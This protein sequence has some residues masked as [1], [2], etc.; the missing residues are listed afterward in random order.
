MH[1]E[2][3]D[4]VAV[5]YA[6]LLVAAVV[7]GGTVVVAAAVVGGG[8]VVVLA[9]VVV[10]GTVVGATSD[11]GPLGSGHAKVMVEATESPLLNTHDT[12][13]TRARVIQGLAPALK[14]SPFRVYGITR[15]VRSKS[16][17]M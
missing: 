6:V 16:P 8:T 15:S 12:L 7:V 5:S 10:G 3:D 1:E 11:R 13:V 4:A 17:S 2:D 14:V 9:A